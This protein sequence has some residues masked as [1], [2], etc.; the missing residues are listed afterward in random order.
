VKLEKI[1]RGTNCAKA[2]GRVWLLGR[3]RSRLSERKQWMAPVVV[4][5]R[6]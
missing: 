3:T 1:R 4:P 2:I 6:R 5:G